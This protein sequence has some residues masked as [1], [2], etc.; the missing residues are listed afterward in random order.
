[1]STARSFVR[2]AI[3]GFIVGALAAACTVKEADDDDTKCNAGDSRACECDDG[4]KGTQKCNAKETGYNECV[5]SSGTGGTANAGGDG[6]TPTAGTAGTSYGGTGG[7]S[8]G[9][10]DAGGE[11]AGGTDAGGAGGA[12]PEDVTPLE[13]Q[14]P[15]NDC[16]TCYFGGCCEQYAPCVNDEE[17]KCLDEVAEILG[18]TDAIKATR[19]VK[20]ADLE[21]CAQTAAGGGVW[22]SG[23]SPLTR[24]V[25]DCIAGEPGWEGA[26]WGALAC[27]ASCFDK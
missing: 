13:C 2:L 22:S 26:P 16:E 12:P 8:Y 7:T 27:K 20:T 18:C 25:I 15:A 4:D 5:C 24:D 9:G 14:N 10:T 6:P 1:M 3:S 11:D 23:V 19:D 17:G 21:A